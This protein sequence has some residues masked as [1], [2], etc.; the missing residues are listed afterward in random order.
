VARYRVE[1]F[2]CRTS[3]ADGD[4]IAA[5][6]DALGA[7]ESKSLRQADVVVVNTCTVTSDA[8]R[9]ARAAI[10]RIQRANPNSRIVVTGCYAQRAP[11][12]IAALPGVFAV[13]GNSH[14]SQVASI[15]LDDIPQIPQNLTFNPRSSSGGGFVPLSSLHGVQPPNLAG[16][17]DSTHAFLLASD[18]FA[19]TEFQLPSFPAATV[20]RSLDAHTARRT[21][22]SLKIQDGC[23]NRC[24]FCVIPSTR[25]NSHSLPRASVLI[26]VKKFVDADGKELVIT[27]I[28][29]GRW[30]RDLTPQDRL[31]D[32]L[33]EIFESTALP[34]LR[35]SSVEPMDWTDGL[36][37]LFGRWGNGD[38][39]GSHPRL[40]RHAHVP[41]QSG[42]D[43]V[44][45][46]MHRRYRPW[47]YAE[48]V[49]KIRAA[50][51]GAAIGAD[52]MVGFPGE[53]DLEFQQN[54]DFIAAQPFTY[55]HLFP[56]SARPGTEGWEM[57]RQNPVP[58]AAVKERM[59]ALRALIDAK[60]LVSRSAFV[61]KQ[62]SAVTL[63]ANETIAAARHSSALTD[64]FLQVE[65]DESHPALAVVSVIITGIT[66]H[67]LCGK[68]RI[69]EHI[70]E[71]RLP[72]SA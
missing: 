65:L 20:R 58:G 63:I 67:G 48:R 45:R 41:L 46:R 13:V 18:I 49:A 39:P 22:P 42:S 64:N 36:I 10:R 6:M 3:Q 40:A 44:L 66:P 33:A 35:I 29:L 19:H 32:L 69:P 11:Q 15:A 55:L 37:A 38:Y 27:G 2:G 62:L 16:H 52:V 26:E 5:A 34:R 53:T 9:D 47:H 70:S 61:G 4:A 57:H 31:E 24:T 25:G 60:N 71:E 17:A 21:R 59:A 50:S 72:H 1:N 30:G 23:G 54:Y 43:A 12:E 14:K 56:F 68:V 28:N 51:P 8:D 7:V